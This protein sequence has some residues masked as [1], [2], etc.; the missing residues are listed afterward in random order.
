MFE[1]LPVHLYDRW[2]SAGVKRARNH[3]RQVNDPNFEMRYLLLGFGVRSRYIRLR[4][5]TI[6]PTTLHHIHLCGVHI[7]L[8]IVT[9]FSCWS[10]YMYRPSRLRDAQLHVHFE[11]KTVQV[12]VE[13]PIV[14][15]EYCRRQL[16]ARYS[17]DNGTHRTQ[18]PS[19]ISIHQVRD[20]SIAIFIRQNVFSSTTCWCCRP[21]KITACSG[22]SS[23]QGRY[24]IPSILYVSDRESRR[25]D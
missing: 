7:L 4:S 24:A 5:I 11:S 15:S 3:C 23:Q 17:P 13:C 16:N 22:F 12:T 9:V 19:T 2:T 14:N 25:K 1:R 6:S 21:R 18:G 8:T 10:A 20:Y